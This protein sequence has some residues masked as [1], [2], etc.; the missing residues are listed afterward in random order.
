MDNSNSNKFSYELVDLGL[1][2]GTL[3][4]DR[5]IG[6]EKITDYGQ[7][8]QWGKTEGYTPT[9]DEYANGALATESKK[10]TWTDYDLGNADGSNF[11]KYVTNSSYGT[12]DNKNTLETVDDGVA[13]AKGIKPN[14][15]M[16]TKKQFQ[17]LIANT[18]NGWIADYNGTGVNGYL[19]VSKTDDTKSVFIPAAGALGVGAVDGV[20]TYGIVWSSSLDEVICFSAWNLGFGDGDVSVGSDYRCYGHPLRGVVRQN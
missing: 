16:P 6:A 3:W 19:F 20:G 10:F 7:Y 13:N 5:N 15:V 11:K 18:N 9:A 2:S 4:A 8:F 14:M 12:A 17:E 1:P